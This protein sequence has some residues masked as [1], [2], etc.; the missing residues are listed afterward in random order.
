[1]VSC[2]RAYLSIPFQEV[3]SQALAASRTAWFCRSLPAQPSPT[4]FELFGY[5]LWRLLNRGAQFAPRVKVVAIQVCCWCLCRGNISRH[6]ILWFN[7]K[8]PCMLIFWIFWISSASVYHQLME[9][10]AR[11]FDGVYRLGQKRR[12]IVLQVRHTDVDVKARLSRTKFLYTSSFDSVLQ[13]KPDF[14]WLIWPQE[15]I[16]NSSCM[17]SKEHKFGEVFETFCPKFKFALPYRGC[18]FQQPAPLCYR[19]FGL[20]AHCH[21]ELEVIWADYSSENP[22]DSCSLLRLKRP[23]SDI[24]MQNRPTP[25]AR[26]SVNFLLATIKAKENMRGPHVYSNGRT[27]PASPIGHFGPHIQL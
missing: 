6:G 5:C 14:S 20:V 3:P 26:C 10:D 18:R 27:E 8:I 2:T 17:R 23:F 1:M 12:S 9:T 19:S 15:C 4:L 16:S 7:Q 25:C 22:N 13:I 24:G 21:L 11:R